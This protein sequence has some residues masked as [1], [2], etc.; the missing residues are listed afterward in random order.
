MGKSVLFRGPLRIDCLRQGI[1]LHAHHQ[2]VPDAAG[3]HCDEP[4]LLGQALAGLYG[5]VQG[6]AEDGA[7]VQRLYE[8]AVLQGDSGA[9]INLALPGFFALSR[10]M[11][12]SISFP[13]W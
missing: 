13:V 2:D 3:L 9:E 4:L 8:S 1:V 12:S 7:D 6:V 5:V 11:I 10:I